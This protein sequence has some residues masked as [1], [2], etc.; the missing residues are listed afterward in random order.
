[1]EA[2]GLQHLAANQKYR[3][4]NSGSHNQQKKNT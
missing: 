2:V 1:M 4:R 3:R